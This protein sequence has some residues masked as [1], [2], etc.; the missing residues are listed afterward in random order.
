LGIAG[1]GAAQFQFM[2]AGRACEHLCAAGGLQRGD[3]AGMVAVRMRIEYPFHVAHPETECADVRLDLR[4]GF[5]Q[6]AVEQGQPL[7]GIHQDRGE[8]V[9]PHVPGVAVDAE[10]FLRRVPLAVGDVAYGLC[11]AGSGQDQAQRQDG[12]G[13]KTQMHGGTPWWR[14][15]SIAAT[16]GRPLARS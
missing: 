8:A 3:A 1:I 6:V 15:C 9:R 5:G 13:K 7:P 4:R 12:A 14:L 11:R 16:T 2:R 10:R